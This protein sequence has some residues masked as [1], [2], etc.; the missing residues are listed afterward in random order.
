MISH[1]TEW[2]EHDVC[3]GPNPTGP[4]VILVLKKQFFVGGDL[5]LFGAMEYGMV[6]NINRG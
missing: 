6:L 5:H 3:A 1:A 4:E 2:E